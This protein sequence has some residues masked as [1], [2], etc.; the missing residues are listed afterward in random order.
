MVSERATM[1]A[2]DFARANAEA[3]AFVR[4]CSPDAWVRTVPG[5]DW[6][7]GVVLH[8]IAESHANSRRWLA[9]NCGPSAPPRST[10]IGNTL[11]KT[12]RWNAASSP[13]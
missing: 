6:T 9:A 10:N 1:L 13:Y 2:E 8:H 5:E 11:R 3:V 7:V 4:T 12:P